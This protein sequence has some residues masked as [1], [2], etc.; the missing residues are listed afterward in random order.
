MSATGTL[1]KQLEE[2]YQTAIGDKEFSGDSRK[3]LKAIN[4]LTY[5]K[6]EDR[7]RKQLTAIVEKELTLT[8]SKKSQELG[9]TFIPPTEEVIKTEVNSRLEKRK[10]AAQ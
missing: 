6:M 7:L 10:Q 2:T 4:G 3:I 9:E 5:T 1:L 8:A